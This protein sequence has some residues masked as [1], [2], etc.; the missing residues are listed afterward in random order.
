VCVCVCVC[1]GGGIMIPIWDNDTHLR[2]LSLKKV[3]ETYIR[4]YDRRQ[5]TDRTETALA[6][7]IPHRCRRHTIHDHKQHHPPEKSLLVQALTKS[8]CQLL[9]K[10]VVLSVTPAGVDT[11][12][13]ATTSTV[14]VMLLSPHHEANASTGNKL[15]IR[16]PFLPCFLQ[17][18][19]H[20]MQL[21]EGCAVGAARNPPLRRPASFNPLFIRA[22]ERKGPS[23]PTRV[24]YYP[25]FFFACGSGGVGVAGAAAGDDAALHPPFQRDGEGV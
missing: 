12:R 15:V 25:I 11:E 23:L 17:P 14:R 21:R 22:R 4:L 1:A 2:C 20:S 5:P 16:A 8:I 9:P 6:R 3:K 10:C 19:P 7:H 24:G 18:F 13:S